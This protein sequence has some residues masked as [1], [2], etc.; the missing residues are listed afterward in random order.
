VAPPSHPSSLNTGECSSQAAV[1]IGRARSGGAN[2]SKQTQLRCDS[3]E[4]I[5]VIIMGDRELRAPNKLMAKQYREFLA[6][7]HKYNI[8]NVRLYLSLC[9][10]SPLPPS[11]HQKHN[12]SQLQQSQT[13]TSSSSM[14]IHTYNNTPTT[15]TPTKTTTTTTTTMSGQATNRHVAAADVCASQREPA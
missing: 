9:V 7:M 6:G 2:S 11:L 15:P 3:F 10:C 14:P 8:A 12:T 13:L 4:S 5:A 1:A